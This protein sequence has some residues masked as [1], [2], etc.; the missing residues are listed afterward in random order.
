MA[1][2][3]INGLM[4]YFK[5][6]EMASQHLRN[7]LF[8]NWQIWQ[9]RYVLLFKH[10]K[11][12]EYSLLPAHDLYLKYFAALH[13]FFLYLWIYIYIY[14]SI[15]LYIYTHTHTHTYIYTYTYINTHTYIYTYVSTYIY[16]YINIYIYIIYIYILY[17]YILDM[18]FYWIVHLRK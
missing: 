12:Q 14:L 1:G 10:L 17:T 8:Q 5:Q 13:W 16:I 18:V 3:I 6:V 11:I 15:Y 4:D 7:I 2:W 9:H